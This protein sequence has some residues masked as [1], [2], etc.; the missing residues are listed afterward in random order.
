MKKYKTIIIVFSIFLLSNCSKEWLEIEPQGRLLEISYY[1]TE[2]EAERGLIAAY[3][4]LRQKFFKSAWSSYYLMANIPSDDSKPVGGGYSDRPEY[5][6]WDD[7]TTTSSNPACAMLW[8]RNYYGI[9][10][11]SV[12]LERI[13]PSSP[14][15]EGYLAEAKFIRAYLYFELIL[16]YGE[17]PLIDH[18]LKQSEYNQTNSTYDELFNLVITDLQEAIG[19]LPVS[20]SGADRYRVTKPAAQALLGKVYLTMASPFFNR[21]QEYYDMAAEQ[22][23]AVIATGDYDLM[24]D[25]DKIWKEEHEHNIESIFEIEY[26]PSNAAGWPDDGIEL[27]GNVEVMLTGVRDLA[28]SDT[29]SNGWGFDMVT[30][31]LVDVYEAEGDEVRLKAVAISEQDL[32]DMGGTSITWSENDEYTGYWSKKRT[33]WSYLT[34]TSG[35][36]AWGYGTNERIIRYADVLL[37]YAEAL[38]RSATPDDGTALEMVNEVRARVSLD[39]LSS[40]GDQLY[41]DIKKERR[42]ELAMEGKRFFDLIRWGDAPE[43]L[44]P[45]GFEEGIHEVFPIPEDEIARSGNVLQQ[46]NGY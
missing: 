29:I 35:E 9:Y 18:V 24:D 41:T 25:Y 32:L 5:W 33:T 8:L 34:A 36:V 7:F 44:G 23:E 3:Q 21:G 19:P 16:F 28:G 11:S 46:N 15:M 13:E 1:Q 17:V 12:L 20:R 45:L 22:F 31:D 26:A 40:S 39:P 14:A 42:M 2:E 38:N 6:E 10:R 43:V 37:M 27:P 30:R 4:M